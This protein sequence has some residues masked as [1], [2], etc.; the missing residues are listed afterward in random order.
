LTTSR[1][2][3]LHHQIYLTLKNEVISGHFR[4]NEPFPDELILSKKFKVSRMT[5]RRAL[6]SLQQ[7]GL[8]V[9]KPGVGTFPLSV[10]RSVK[11]ND[12]I[13]TFRDALNS[14]SNQF[15]ERLL[16]SSL[17]RTPAFLRQG[18]FDFGE[19]C[20]RVAKLYKS[21]TGPVH[22]ATNYIP[23]TLASSM[24]G[25]KLTRDADLTLLEELGIKSARTD[26]AFSAAAADLEAAKVLR[27]QVGVPLINT[28]RM[29]FNA[30]NQPI[31]YMES[32]TRPDA[33]Q[34]VFSFTSGDRNHKRI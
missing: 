17:I 13:D 30:S 22:F 1:I 26:M 10:D 8:I 15:K 3:P 7:E 5:L 2:V 20:L 31:E 19:R 33:Y 21:A 11:F 9:R 34:Y 28:R 29:S 25:K 16:S 4:L 6:A 12:S 32:L 27:V 14:R 18:K 23:E 24:R